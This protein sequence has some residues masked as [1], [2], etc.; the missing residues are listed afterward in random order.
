MDR[1]H[2]GGTSLAATRHIAFDA[3]RRAAPLRSGERF[4]LFLSR[5][6]GYGTLVGRPLLI[7][8]AIGLLGAFGLLQIT[9]LPDVDFWPLALDTTASPLTFIRAIEGDELTRVLV[10][11]GAWERLVVLGVRLIGA[12]SIVFA[13]IGIRTYSRVMR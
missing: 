12:A 4:L 3:R 9:A 8:L 2:V 10:N 11:G 6:W 1:Q 7:W 5:L 13:V